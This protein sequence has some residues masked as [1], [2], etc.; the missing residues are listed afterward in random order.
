VTI[1]IPLKNEAKTISKLCESLEA[2]TFDA[3]EVIFVDGG[4]TDH[5]IPF[6]ERFIQ[7]RPNYQ[8]MVI[9]GA[10][11]AKARNIGIAAASTAI[12]ACTDAGVVLDD[13]W[14]E[15]L[16]KPFRDDTIEF[17]SG[18]YVGT[19]ENFTQRAIMTL[20]YPKIEYISE[21]TFLPSSRSI[22]FKKDLWTKIGGYPEHLEKAE[23]TYFDLKAFELGCTIALAKDAIVYWPPRTS[24]T[25]LFAQYSSYAEWDTKA[26]LLL[27]VRVYRQLFFA[28]FL[29]FIFSVLSFIGG[30]LY[31]FILCGIVGSYLI[32]SGLTLY[33]TTR[34]FV[35]FLLGPAVK[36]TIF[37]AEST[38]L[39]KGL[40]ERSKSS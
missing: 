16:L 17:V 36:V 35:S 24:L 12:I 21:T 33:Q 5:T 19:A 26:G 34:K 31:F 23:D 3:F 25:S 7:N 32:L 18:V 9:E 4:S 13:H 28:Y 30:S 29:I 38:G 39:L 8:L 22:A 40:L 6:I 27:K 14:L 37:L 15:N 11:R 20:Q 10:N 1:V 2:Q